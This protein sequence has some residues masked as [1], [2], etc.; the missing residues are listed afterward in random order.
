MMQ[1][2]RRKSNILSLLLLFMMVSLLT[3]AVRAMEWG[4]APASL[5]G[6]T[7]EIKAI[8]RFGATG[9]VTVIAKGPQGSPQDANFYQSLS[10]ISCIVMGPMQGPGMGMPPGPGPIQTT[11]PMP[12]PGPVQGAGPMPGSGMSTQIVENF[13]YNT[14]SNDMEGSFT[15]S[16]PGLY[17]IEA[18]LASGESV[19]SGRVQVQFLLS[20]D[21]MPPI[22]IG[23]GEEKKISLASFLGWD[24]L[25]LVVSDVQLDQTSGS[26]E[27]AI[28]KAAEGSSV[29]A[30]MV[31]GVKAGSDL[32]FTA[33]VTYS[34]PDG[35]NTQSAHLTGTVTVT[36]SG[37]IPIN[38]IDMIK[39]LLPSTSFSPS[40]L[41]IPLALLL[42]LVTG[43]L[44]YSKFF[45]SVP[46]IFVV[47]C[48]CGG[49]PLSREVA[50][51]KGNSF[52]LY[53]LVKCLL[54]EI[55]ERNSVVEAIYSQRR[56]LRARQY[57]I[58]LVQD[59]NFKGY[60]FY[61]GNYLEA[62]NRRKQVIYAEMRE[63]HLTISVA[64]VSPDD[65]ESVAYTDSRH[66][67]SYSVTDVLDT[68]DT[69]DTTEIL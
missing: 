3:G 66:G 30:L 65:Q 19:F 11:G 54:K 35:F 62:L 46:G 22:E 15:V 21:P 5:D 23:R 37:I 31:K 41:V 45:V 17:S 64:F 58:F 43:L 50:G 25:S 1:S 20:S 13:S 57:R 6:A 24:G 51:P 52:T 26:A 61:R 18:A 40:F 55:E 34:T 56:E 39:S 68:D 42:L 36:P 28:S 47:E 49:V 29:N 14:E 59:E 33:D 12:G 7:L 38:P 32:S 63:T 53:A 44:I 4:N 48:D 69:D 60:A 2:R 9:N 27:A 16:T 67:D 8:Q 10:S